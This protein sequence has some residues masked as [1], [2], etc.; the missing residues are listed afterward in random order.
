MTTSSSEP[1]R[2]IRTRLRSLLGGR[3]RED[4][5]MMSD[6]RSRHPR[7]TTAVRADLEI[8]ARFRGERNEFRSRTDAAIQA[9]RLAMVGEAFF[10]QCCYRA[11]ARCQT[12][13]IPALPRVLH[14]LA[15]VT[16]QISIGDP[17]VVLPG[18]YIPHG[19]VV[20]DGFTEVGRGAVLF[21]FVNLGLVAGNMHGPKIGPRASIGTGAKVIGPVRIGRAAKI[22]ANAVVLSDVPDHATAIGVPA[23]IVR[24]DGSAHPR[25]DGD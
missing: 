14:R 24:H 9:V 1:V 7:F 23:R 2:S 16:A 18:V 3:R 17:V 22:G 10:A 21:P 20:I 5:P 4:R 11:K 19:Q 12:L 15:I 6:V 25:S 13:G 8:A